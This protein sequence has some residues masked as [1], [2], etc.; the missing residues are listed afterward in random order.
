MTGEPAERIRT[1]LLRSDNQLKA[2]KT[3]RALAAL[4]DAREVAG[5]EGVDERL[6]ELVTR[7]IESLGPLLEGHAA[8]QES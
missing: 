6:R 5:T 7:R 1:L 8:D 4:E 3:E 2:G